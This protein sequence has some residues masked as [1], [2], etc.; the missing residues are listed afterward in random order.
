[1]LASKPIILIDSSFLVL[2]HCWCLWT[3]QKWYI[4]VFFHASSRTSKRK[5]RPAHVRVP[6]WGAWAERATVP[7]CVRV[8]V[9]FPTNKLP[10]MLCLVLFAYI[11]HISEV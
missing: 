6:M 10:L 3:R 9:L 7:S 5:P 2:T 1:M 8:H 4:L 11:F